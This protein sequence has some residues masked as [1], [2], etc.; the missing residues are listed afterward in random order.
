MSV[1]CHTQR[2]EFGLARDE[3]YDAIDAGVLQYRQAYM[4]GNP[5]LRLLRHEAEALA[6][7]KHGDRHQ[8]PKPLC[9]RAAAFPRKRGCFPAR[10][11][12]T[13]HQKT[14]TTASSPI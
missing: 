6:R 5:W 13:P 4:H 11:A 10:P 9:A 3:I 12:A 8:Y 1:P 14:T 7:S 2:E